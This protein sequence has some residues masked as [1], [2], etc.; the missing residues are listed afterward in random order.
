M[1]ARKNDIVQIIEDRWKGCLVHV[2]RVE[3][4]G[5]QGFVSIPEKGHAFIRLK[6]SQYAI[7]GQSYLKIK[8]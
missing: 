7:I 5:I 8:N 2:V 1:I 6:H 4:W 3:N